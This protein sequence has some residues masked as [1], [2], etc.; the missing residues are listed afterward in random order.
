M[1]QLTSQSTQRILQE[2]QTR[3][4]AVL[5]GASGIMGASGLAAMAA[6]IGWQVPALP[7]SEAKA[8]RGP[9]AGNG[10]AGTAPRSLSTVNQQIVQSYRD[11][12][13]IFGDTSQVDVAVMDDANKQEI[14]LPR[15]MMLCAL[16][17]ID[18][19]TARGDVLEAYGHFKTFVRGYLARGDLNA[20]AALEIYNPYG[21]LSETLYLR[22]RASL[23]D[24]LFEPEE[25]FAAAITTWGLFP[26]AFVERYDALPVVP[27][28]SERESM[29]G[30]EQ[31]LQDSWQKQ[32]ARLTAQ[33]TL[34]FAAALVKTDVGEGEG[35]INTRLAQVAP[36]LGIVKF[37][38]DL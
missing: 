27:S 29:G 21:Y 10:Q 37:Q 6:V 14:A 12:Y 30:G 19:I 15:L 11:R 24:R 5:L 33:N 35:A 4:E 34:S 31:S 3:R 16:Q 38:L 1:Y 25:L 23:Q 26:D 9:R 17:H 36:R 28:G 8:S 22:E 13:A 2:R 18:P 20:P 7:I 32:L